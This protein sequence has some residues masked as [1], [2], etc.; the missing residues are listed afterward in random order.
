MRSPLPIL[1]YLLLLILTACQ[2]WDLSDPLLQSALADSIL[3]EGSRVRI[4][5]KDYPFLIEMIEDPEPRIRL[6]GLK[7]AE[8]NL[9]TDLFIPILGATLDEFPEVSDEA[10]AILNRQGDFFLPWVSP[11]LKYLDYEILLPALGIIV[12]S[13][14][15]ESIFYIMELYE[16]ESRA[17]SRAASE[18][19]AGLVEPEDP[20]LTDLQNREETIYRAAYY[21]ILSY[22]ENPALIPLILQGLEDENT[23]VRGIAVTS[24]YGFRDQAIPYLKEAMDNLTLPL[25]QAIIQ[26]MEQTSIPRGIP[27]LIGLLDSD[28]RVLSQRSAILMVHYNELSL[29]YIETALE[30]VSEES[31][32]ALF[33]VLDRIDSPKV[34]PL[35]TRLLQNENQKIWV[36]ATEGLRRLGKPAWSDLR[37][38]L[39]ITQGQ[40]FYRILALLREQGDP[41]LLAGTSGIL[42]QEWALQMILSSS[43][44]QIETY[45]NKSGQM[46]RYG[47]ETLLL[48]EAAQLASSVQTRENPPE[49]EEEDPFVYQE[50]YKSWEKLLDQANLLEIR[51]RESNQSFFSTGDPEKL[52]QSKNLREESDALKEEAR[53][54]ENR[55]ELLKERSPEDR[56]AID[57]YLRQ[58]DRLAEI[59]QSLSPSFKELGN[60][61]YRIW[62][63]DGESLLR[64]KRLNS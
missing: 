31:L 13:S 59:W 47:R 4:R 45:L 16:M 61:I 51:A 28:Y 36:P 30:Q 11:Q 43:Y 48:K 39:R 63:M 14:Y 41:E 7:L 22:Y 55:L 37:S 52:K 60:R 58:K 46:N 1:L 12:E 27:L 40:P 56:E 17:I 26:F 23:T 15:Q 35:Y 2:S 53:L 54:L 29:P 42:N 25:A 57:Q 3:N 6:T 64:L 33:W 32:P 44:N 62:G 19:M 38:V 24:L 5:D 10:R 9:R 18:A 34:I 21:Q 20:R 49:T 50:L 8:Y